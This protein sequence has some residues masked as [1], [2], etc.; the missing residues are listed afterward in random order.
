MSVDKT[1]SVAQRQRELAEQIVKILR[2]NPA[3]ANSFEYARIV[4]AIAHYTLEMQKE[5]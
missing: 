5:G 3:N 1:K 4:E 2:S